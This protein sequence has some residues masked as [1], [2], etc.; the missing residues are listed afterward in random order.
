M[1]TTNPLSSLG[2]P[3]PLLLGSASF[4]R[5]LILKEMS[6]P[7]SKFVR[8]IDEKALGDRSEN[9]PPREL[10]LLLA[11]AK[12]DRLV[13]ELKEN[14]PDDLPG[15]MSSKGWV[16]LTGDQV[17]T[18]GGKILEKP[19]S[20]EEAKEFVEGYAKSPPSTVGSVV[21]YHHPSG[22][23]VDGVDTATIHF[24][25][26]TLGGGGSATLI[27]SLIEQGEPVMSCAGGL[28]I[29]HP[30]T[31]HHVDRIDGTEDSVMGLSKDLVS[32]LLQELAEKLPKEE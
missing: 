19:E 5:K 27:D 30:L 10:V 29:E 2:L 14:S 28:M 4:T 9:A 12:M 7:F 32:R 15:E 1:A 6:V 21:L 24:N 18:C 8:P 23:R 20:V 3:E 26:E 25:P 13:Q 17:V 11:N 16:V 31:Q 22:I